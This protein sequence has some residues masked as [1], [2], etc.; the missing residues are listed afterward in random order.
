MQNEQA[1]PATQRRSLLWDTVAIGLLLIAAWYLHG[2][3]NYHRYSY[4]ESLRNWVTLSWVV[5]GIRYYVHRWYPVAILAVV[6]AVLFNPVSRITMT[7]WQWHPYDQ[8]TMILSLAAA[9]GLAVLTF[10][11]GSRKDSNQ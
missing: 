10:R 4:Y 3:G 9:V 2:T 6:M 1:D 8:L 11:P 5:A 7:K